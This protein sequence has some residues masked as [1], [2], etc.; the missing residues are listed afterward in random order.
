LEEES[1]QTIVKKIR[2]AVSRAV[3]RL[4]AVKAME[5]KL[6]AD[7]ISRAASRVVRAANKVARAKKVVSRVT[8]NFSAVIEVSQIGLTSHCA[9]E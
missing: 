5:R 8:A 4:R 7:K 3:N 1:W 9:A 2:V 6:V